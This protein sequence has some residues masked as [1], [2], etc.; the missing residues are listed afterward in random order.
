MLQVLLY[1]TAVEEGGGT[2]F[3]DLVLRDEGGPGRKERGEKRG[4]LEVEAAVGKLLCFHNCLPGTTEP[5]SR[6]LH[7]GLPVIKGEKWAINKWFRAEPARL[8]SES[9]DDPTAV[10]LGMGA[11]TRHWAL[12]L[13]TVLVRVW[14]LCL[15]TV[16]G[17]LCLPF[18][19]IMRGGP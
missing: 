7:A 14:A 4:P 18:V 17:A 16:F 2:A 13:G 3:T 8:Q 6:L 5:D 9:S 12:C 19:M 1:L 15:V 11:A 10:H